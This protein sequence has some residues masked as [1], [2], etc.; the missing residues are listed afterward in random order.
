M[1][2]TEPSRSNPPCAASLLSF[3]QYLKCQCSFSIKPWMV[4]HGRL[5]L[6]L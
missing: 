1:P 4:C 5:L 2:H 6:G 3:R